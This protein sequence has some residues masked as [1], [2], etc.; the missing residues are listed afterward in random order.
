MS[1]SMIADGMQQL[2]PSGSAKNGRKSGGLN[3]EVRRDEPEAKMKRMFSTGPHAT[4]DVRARGE[5]GRRIASDVRRALLFSLVLV[6]VGII[7][8]EFVKIVF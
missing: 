2:P 4:L 6:T 3:L 7:L 1:R 5:R 8:A